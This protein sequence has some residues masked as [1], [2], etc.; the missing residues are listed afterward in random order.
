MVGGPAR[1]SSSCVPV[2]ICQRQNSEE[3]RLCIRS[4][5]PASTARN[6]LDR[7]DSSPHLSLHHIAAGDLM[8]RSPHLHLKGEHHTGGD[9]LTAHPETGR[10]KTGY[11]SS[12]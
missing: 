1:L 8:Q 3:A 11:A 7:P 12:D 6:L 9:A 5:H 4:H 10:V 2:T